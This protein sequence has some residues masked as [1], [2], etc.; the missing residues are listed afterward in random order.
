M[1]KR[2]RKLVLELIGF[3]C[4]LI[5]VIISASTMGGTHSK[6]QMLGL[7]A[8]SFGAGAALVNAIRDYA[9]G[10]SDG[11]Y[12]GRSMAFS[13][14]DRAAV[15]RAGEMF[16]RHATAKPRN[17][18]ASAAL[19]E[20]DAIMLPPGQ[21]PIAGKSAIE[22][23]LSG[24]PPFSHYQL[25]AVE[26]EGNGDLA[27]ER[28]NASMILTPVAASPQEWRIS[29]LIIW[30]RQRDGLWKVAREMFTP[31]AAPAAQG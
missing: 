16:A 27:Y 6:A 3:F 7:I 19:Y 26:I 10:R 29:Y 12:G 30:R 25:Q 13:D 5:V 20:D 4:S 17:D 11:K 2:K 8:G 24:F 18:R 21:V 1:D 15:R 23:F 9:A 28:G 22:A 14:V 31:G